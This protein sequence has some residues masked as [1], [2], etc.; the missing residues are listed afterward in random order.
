[1][2]ANGQTI[3]NLGRLNIAFEGDNRFSNHVLN[4]I[5]AA[6][7]KTDNP[8]Q[9]TFRFVPDIDA[10]DNSI[11]IDALRGV[12]AGLHAE[13]TGRMLDIAPRPM[14]PDRVIGSN[15]AIK[16]LEMN[17][18]TLDALRAKNFVYKLFN[19]AVQIEQLSLGQSF[20][21]ASALTKNRRTIAVLGKGGVGKTSAMLKLCIQDGWRYLSDDLA[22]VDD[23]GVVYRSPA[24]L[25]VYAYNT[26]G[27]APMER[28][29]MRGRILFDRLHWRIRRRLLGNAKVRRRVS[30]EFLFGAENVARSA[31]LTDVLFLQ[32][33]G[34]PGLAITKMAPQDAADRITPIIMN[35]IK[36]YF[37]IYHEVAARKPELLPS[38]EDIE[39]KTRTVLE[40]AFENVQAKLMT[41]GPDAEPDDLAN[42]IRDLVRTSS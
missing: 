14:A 15:L 26:E 32:R 33:G 16:A 8:P 41:A 34:A 4:E 9:L 19:W 17:F 35:E 13:H 18:L 6:L 40:H 37:P 10:R 1:M 29:L 21:H 3:V 27:D 24:H 36:A 28:R 39:N 23:A 20:I 11:R 5:A 31:S 38:P 42:A 7:P 30:A 25:Q 12:I 2:N 22:V